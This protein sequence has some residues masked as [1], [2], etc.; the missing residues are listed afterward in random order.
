MATTPAVREDNFIVVP[1]DD[2]FESPRLVTSAET[3][4][5]ALHPDRF[6]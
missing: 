6:Q 4:A 5:K 1:L 3:I 2:F